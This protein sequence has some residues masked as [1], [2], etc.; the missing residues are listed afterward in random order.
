MEL[1]KA[2]C[3]LCV[4]SYFCNCF[5][6]F[7]SLVFFFCFL[8]SIFLCL[9]VYSCLSKSSIACEPITCEAVSVNVKSNMLWRKTQNV[10][11]YAVIPTYTL[12]NQATEQLAGHGEREEGGRRGGGERWRACA[13]ERDRYRQ[14]KGRSVQATAV[15]PLRTQQAG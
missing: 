14:K 7:L 15:E 2:K 1:F 8:L 5:C 11:A 13:W 3:W 4:N 10:A 6:L 9:C 12:I